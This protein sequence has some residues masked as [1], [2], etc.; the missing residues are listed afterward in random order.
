VKITVCTSCVRKNACVRATVS[1]R[2][3]A[4]PGARHNAFENLHLG[5]CG[6]H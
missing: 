6:T 2:L 5:T 1:E 3:E 4:I